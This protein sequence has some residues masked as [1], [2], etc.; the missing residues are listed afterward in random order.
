MKNAIKTLLACSA[1]MALIQSATAQPSTTTTPAGL[2]TSTADWSSYAFPSG[3]YG[4]PLTTGNILKASGGDVTV[5]FL[6]PTGAAYEESLFVV[7]PNPG[8]A[9]QF[10]DNKTTPNGTTYDLG[11]YAAGTEIE[12]GLY[13]DNTGNTWY[14]GPASR[15]ADGAVHANIVGDYEGLADTSF[16]GFEDLVYPGG[17]FNYVDEV[18]AFTGTEAASSVPDGGMTVALLGGA[19]VGLQALR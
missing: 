14:D 2:N 12:F 5:T 15:N 18:F 16:V 7:N 19:L 10:M 4:V 13:V 1:I 6:G 8:D 3:S 11:T 17:D 9:G